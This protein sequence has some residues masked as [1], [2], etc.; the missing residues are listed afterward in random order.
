MS[1]TYWH[2]LLANSMVD[3]AKNSKTKSAAYAL[4]IAFEELTDAY[5]SLEDKHF[6]EEYLEEGWKKRREWMEEHNLIDKW[7]RLVYLCKK[8]IEGREDHLKEMFDIIESLRIS[9]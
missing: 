3:L 9:L 8:V 6:H 1:D 5:A 2:L 7:E 4:L